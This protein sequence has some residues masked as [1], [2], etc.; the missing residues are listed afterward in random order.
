MHPAW[1]IDDIR[2]LLFEHLE[3]ASLARLAQTC[4]IFFN[5]A[6]DELWKTITSVSAFLSCFP[7]DY[8]RRPLHVDDLQRLHF[9][10]A[11]IRNVI[12]ESEGIHRTI[13][14]PPQFNASS[15]MGKVGSDLKTWEQLWSE[16]ATIRPASSFLVNLK[17]VRVSCIAEELLI[18]LVGITGSNITQIYIK[19][20]TNPQ[21][22]STVLRMLDQLQ[23]TSKLE[24]LFVRD[25][26]PDP[27]VLKVIQASPLKHL[28]LDPR[29]HGGKHAG[30]HFKMIPLRLEILEK[31][32]LEKLTIGLTRDWC[33]PQI[34]ASTSKYLPALQTLW[35]NLT[36][37]VAED[38]Q[39]SCI[40]TATPWTCC[41][42]LPNSN[43]LA[44]SQ[45][46]C[47]RRPPTLFFEKLDNP[48]LSLL[49]LKFHFNATGSM[50][51][52]IISS[53]K[54]S[55]R[56]RHLTELALA[57]GGWFNNCGECGAR[58]PPRIKPSELRSAMTMLLP[59]PQLRVLRISVAPNFLSIL[60]LDLY[61]TIT[62]GIQSLEVLSLGHREFVASSEFDGVVYYERVS[63]H[64]LAAFCSM[65]PN[66]R[67]V[68]VGTVD[69]TALE[70]TPQT[71]WACHSVKDL[72]IYNV[73]G[74]GR[75]DE[76]ACQSSLRSMVNIF[77]PS[78]DGD[79]GSYPTVTRYG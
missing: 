15:K 38:C 29:V 41:G 67:K 61:R 47:G 71:T 64:H 24:Y 3:P 66:L 56:L 77:F 57:G 60:D 35:L 14:L 53:L 8:R 39:N 28:R 54:K 12:L 49:N 20:I 63:L 45:T 72:V 11:K 58:P 13:R 19:Y 48:K 73:I 40:N 5:I 2:H 21:K 23:D 31:S 22:N 51:L 68:D 9:Y 37:F 69:M 55:C 4:K 34:A 65:L 27:V 33:T 44:G 76:T 7:L 52:D 43:Q 18:P 17:C 26:E 75:G 10:S 6:T 25:S 16:I 1:E 70:G 78:L 50:F 74:V 46:D 32:T 59:L 30:F 79:K 62:G 36:T 42:A